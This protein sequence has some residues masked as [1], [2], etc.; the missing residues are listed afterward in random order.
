MEYCVLERKNVI[1][2]A[3]EDMQIPACY[4]M[5]GVCFL[6]NNIKVKNIKLPAVRVVGTEAF[7]NCTA[8]RHAALPRVYVIKKG[9][10]GNCSN[11]R[12]ILL[13]KTVRELGKGVFDGCKRMEKA[14][15]D[16]MGNCRILPDMTFA[17]C[18]ALSNVTLPEVMWTIGNQ[19]FYKCESL[20]DIKFPDKLH[21][22]ENQ[23]FYQC[24]LKS[25]HFP[26]HL[27]MI[28]ESAFLKCKK[29]EYVFIPPSVQK[30]GKWAFHGCNNLKVLEI[31]H[32]PQDVGEWLTNKNCV[33]RCRR[34]SKMETYAA[35]Y[36]IQ[37]EYADGI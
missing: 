26:E 34:G 1:R 12:E 15:F 13:P 6:K 21:R 29:L 33:I 5:L 23:A 9:A 22:I 31:L 19:A 24:G 4:Q 2:A 30:I 3:E 11:L 32:D 27:E 28:G 14:L 8:L 7:F 16:P 18:R 10:F 20:E 17:N 25:L 35:Q 37:V 36:G